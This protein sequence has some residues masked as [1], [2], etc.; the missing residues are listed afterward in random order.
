MDA[1]FL[2][3]VNCRDPWVWC[4]I[5]YIFLMVVGLTPFDTGES[6]T[7]IFETGEGNPVRQALLLLIAGALGWALKAKL[8]NIL[9]LIGLPLGFIL[10]W[11]GI[12]VFWAPDFGISF[13][14]FVFLLVVT[15]IAF[16]LTYKLGA[17]TTLRILAYLLVGLVTISVLSGPIIPGAQHQPGQG[18]AELIGNWKGI[19]THKNQAGFMGAVTI[20]LSIFYWQKNRQA[21][22]ALG[23]AGGLV[24]LL[25]SQ[26]KTALGLLLPSM[27]LG[28]LAVY[29]Q[30]CTKNMIG[31]VG[32]V[33]AGVLCLGIIWL[34]FGDWLLTYLADPTAFTGRVA[35]WE[36]LCLV[37]Q[38][39]P[40]FGVGF[41]S[42]YHAGA[43]TPLLNYA[44]DW[45]MLVA[46]G[47][48][49][50]LD[51]W[52][53]IGLLGLLLSVY[54]LIIAPLFKVSQIRNREYKFVFWSFM[55]FTFAQNF[56]ESSLLVPNSGR[57]IVLL[58]F[59]ASIHKFF[60]EN[61]NIN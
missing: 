28:G 48:N 45:I 37:I 20:L 9:K 43:S 15:W 36:T 42:L 55:I 32:V 31:A 21:L 30:Q 18:A 19:F 24:L 57:W 44:N 49:G 50:I 39:N 17:E 61:N 7:D 25:M 13:R 53:S 54:G 38:D 14:R 33:V 56:L 2:L 16:A 47:H 22:W 23:I 6:I 11:C 34:A 29:L 59:I 35:I 8:A 26:S 46:H 10:L 40:W 60:K 41:G 52:A 27:L 4:F 3:T 12:T 5:G 1:K 58:I 51:I